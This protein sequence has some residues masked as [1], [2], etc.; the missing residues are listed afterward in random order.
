MKPVRFAL[1]IVA[2]GALLGFTAVRAQNPATRIDAAFEKFW[3]AASPAEAERTVDA[4]VKSGASFGEAMQR[5]KQ[6]RQ[7][8][9]QSAGVVKLMN[10]AE[11]GVE[12]FYALNVPANYDPSRRYQMRF[13]LHGGVGGRTTNQ[14]RGNGEIGALTGAEQFYVLPYAWD[15]APWWSDDQVLNMNA[16]VDSVKRTYN[17]DENRVIVSGVSDGGTGAYYVGMRDT[18]PY[19]SFTPLNGFIMVLSNADID[20]GK[21]FPNNLRNK[22]MFVINGGKDPL[23]PTASVEPSVM[24]LKNNGVSVDYHPQPE[25]GHNTAWWPQMKDTYEK[26]AADHPRNPYPDKLTWEVVNGS[27][28]RAHWLVIDQIGAQPGDPKTLP[29]LNTDGLFQLF[30]RPKP[31]G[32]ADLVKM[33]NTVEATTKGVAALTLLLSPDK[34]DFDQPVK[35]V[36]NGRTVFN[37]KV[38]RD[39]KTLLKWAALDNDRTMLYAAELRI[40]LAR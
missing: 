20:D 9:P 26:F 36:A 8:A 30:D 40:K 33:G 6:G 25:A 18:T 32:R 5:L 16:I 29:D 4:I 2:T 7:Y 12:H 14:P 3:S 39:L 27:R 38:E 31:T 23:Y 17:I 34:F 10:R 28:N 35:V 19:A 11:D 22:P 37:G 24:H 1:A 21:I 15:T 13:Q